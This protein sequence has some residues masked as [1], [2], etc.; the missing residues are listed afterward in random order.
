MKLSFPSA[1]LLT[2]A[3]AWAQPGQWFY[4]PL[5]QVKDFVQLSD[6]QLQTILTNN[7]EY[8][9]RSS[10]K[11]SRI[12]EVQTEIAQETGKENLDPMAL[13]VRYA[14][15]ESICREMKSQATAYQKKNVDVLTDPQKARLKILEDALKLAPV[16]AEAQSG[17]LIGGVNY[18]PPFFTSS[19]GSTGITIGAI[20]GPAIGCYSQFP[21]VIQSG[22]FGS[23]PPNGIVI[24]ANRVS[25]APNPASPNGIVNRWFDTPKFVTSGR[26]SQ[27]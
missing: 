25:G 26:A 9:R 5:G 24:P 12:Q 21:A 10:G 7:D 13:G 4:Q 14:E 22:D 18:T 23:A 3:S 8:N 6:S 17:N 27:K 1:L 16:L 2:I 19:F 20:F 15:V 11:Q